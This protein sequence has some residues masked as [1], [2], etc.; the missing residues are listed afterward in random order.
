MNTFYILSLL[1]L[2]GFIFWTYIFIYKKPKQ[3]NFD[4]NYLTTLK[5]H[6]DEVHFPF[7]YLCD[8][9]KN[10]IPIVLISAFFRD[11]KEIKLYQEYKKKGVAI[12]GI[13]AYK[14][15]P[16]PITDN[17]GDSKIVPF[18]YL[19]EIQHWLSCFKEPEQYGFTS[20]H[21]LENISESDFYDV[22]DKI[23][24]VP[25]KN[26]AVSTDYVKKYDFI[27]VC[28]KDD[29]KCSVDGWNAINRNFR[30]AMNCFPIM[31]NEMGLKGLVIGRVNCGLEKLYGERITVMDFLPYPEFQN[32]LRESRFLFVPNVYDASPRVISEAIIKGV[33]VLLNRGIVCGSKY[34]TEETGEFFFDENDVRFSVQKLLNKMEKIDPQKWWN[35]NYSKAKSA[36]KL[37]DILNNWF[38]NLI[39]DTKEISFL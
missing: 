2:I 29:D 35:Q 19:G 13:T 10:I 30:L 18:D 23:P 12:V 17:S 6:K 31:I 7:R 4:N 8:E 21:Q 16:K 37:R 15:F 20:Q 26:E 14:S 34:I 9:N 39:N 1:L 33:P 25:N 22:E 38:P 28:L 11:D 3:E 27:Y 5:Q 24:S 36:K 32:K